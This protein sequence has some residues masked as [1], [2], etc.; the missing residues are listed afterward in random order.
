LTALGSIGT[1]QPA[2]VQVTVTC[3]LFIALKEAQPPLLMSMIVMV[4]LLSMMVLMLLLLLMHTAAVT[5]S[6]ASA[7]AQIVE[8]HSTVVQVTEGAAARIMRTR[9]IQQA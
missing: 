9:Q 3:I 5:V 2:T 6:T 7:A 4:V 1:L 8:V